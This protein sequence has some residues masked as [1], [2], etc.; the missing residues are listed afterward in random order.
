[1]AKK[2]AAKKAAPKK[3]AK[4]AQVKT[5]KNKASV[6]DF[7]ASVEVE[8]RRADAKAV[9]RML[10]EVTGA[11]PAMWGSAIV[12]Y[13]EYDYTNTLGAATWPKIGFSPRKQ[14]LVLYIMP[15]FEKYDALMKKL[16]KYKTGKSCLYINKLADVDEKVLREL[17]TLSWK[18]MTEKYG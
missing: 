17:A 1:M 18:R 6:A 11:K 3:A 4:Q 2:A 12:G 7:I 9:D 5:Q 10:R 15:G 16:G 14:S 8:T 13:G